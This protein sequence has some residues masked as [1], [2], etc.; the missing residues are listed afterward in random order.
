MHFDYY[1]TAE[2]LEE[3]TKQWKK[4]AEKTKGVKYI[5]RLAPWNKKFHWTIFLEMDNVACL[6]DFTST[7]D[8]E[9][10]YSKDT[11]GVWEIYN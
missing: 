10:D 8:Y 5:A 2:E 11:H 9:R 3:L 7:W 4:Q 1:G 6:H